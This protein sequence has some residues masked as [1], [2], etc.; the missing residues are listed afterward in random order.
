M[1]KVAKILSL[2]LVLVMALS[3]FALP[4]SALDVTVQAEVTATQVSEDASGNKIYKIDVWVDS[5]HSLTTLQLNLSWDDAAF[6]LLRP[7]YNNA[8]VIN[9][10]MVIDKDDPELAMYDGN[11]YQ[12]HDGAYMGD[13]VNQDYGYAMFPQ[14]G[15]QPSLARI[16][17]GN[18]GDALVEQGYT[19]LYWAWMVDYT[20]NYL[21]ISGG[22]QR[23]TESPLS[24]RI[25][26]LAF[27]LKEKADA[28]DG[29]YTIGFN[30]AQTDRLTGT[31]TVHDV[32]DSV[33]SSGVEN[34]ASIRP[35]MV[36]YTNAQIAIGEDGPAV[37]KSRAQ[38]KMTATSDTTVADA[39]TFR[40]IS[41][42]TDADWDAY[43]AN[44]AAGGDTSA[45]QRLGFVAYKGTEGFDME[46][47]KAVAQG[48][49][50]E[51]YDVAWTDYVQKADDSS[52]AYFGARL[53]ITSAETR[54]DVTYV[55]VVEYLNADGTTAYA[56]YDAAEQ[57]LLNTNY[58]TI[59][60]D[61]LA[62]YPYEA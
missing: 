40:V 24:G 55:G 35:A 54:S 22:D 41:T 6:Q 42:I 18:L 14:D 38:V 53:E 62:T 52:D 16:S 51:G 20:D 5:S 45:I 25:K 17:D 60:E 29:N 8:V 4:A 10:N 48:T 46:T 32:V 15:T 58:D 21:T 59:V 31:Y 12:A 28:P 61:Y 2:A 37:A 7:N 56:F 50:T 9:A 23:G 3:V 34:S 27:Y 43:F 11:A 13:N 36:S 47:A 49:P 44:T 30:E 57:A 39:F 26:V 1:K 19:G 33:I